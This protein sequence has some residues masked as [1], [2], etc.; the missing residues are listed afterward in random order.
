VIGCKSTFG[1]ASDMERH[2]ISVHNAVRPPCPVCGEGFYRND[3]VLVHVREKHPQRFETLP[4]PHT[5]APHLPAQYI[6]A[7]QFLTTITPSFPSTTVRN[8]LLSSTAE[9]QM[10]SF[11]LVAKQRPVQDIPAEFDMDFVELFAEPYSTFDMP[12]EPEEFPFENLGEQHPAQNV[13]T[14]FDKHFPDFFPEQHPPQD[15][16]VE[17]EESLLELFDEQHP[18]QNITAELDKGFPELLAEQHPV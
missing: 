14:E 12:F 5:P 13:S 10:I 11:E 3:K 9:P 8:A 2:C 17:V 18:I 15:V 7:E 16:F 1:R 6:P 4:A